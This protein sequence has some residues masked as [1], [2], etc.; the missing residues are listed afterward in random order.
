MALMPMTVPTGSPNRGE[1][2]EP[3]NPPISIKIPASQSNCVDHPLID[4]SMVYNPSNCSGWYPT[5][6]TP[7]FNK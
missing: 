7:Y 1:P 5:P 6:V 3:S 4:P 2:P